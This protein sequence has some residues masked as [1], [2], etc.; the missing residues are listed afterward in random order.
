M[1]VR[2][3]TPNEKEISHG[4]VSCKRSWTSF[5]VGGWRHRRHLEGQEAVLDEVI[6][7]TAFPSS[8]ATLFS[9]VR[10]DARWQIRWSRAISDSLVWLPFMRHEKSIEAM[11]WL[12]RHDLR[13]W[14]T[15][16]T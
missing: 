16:A 12:A 11:S 14:S 6:V 5:A 7:T 4:R 1:A 3:A 2:R 15:P 8:G 13:A 9:L 10:S